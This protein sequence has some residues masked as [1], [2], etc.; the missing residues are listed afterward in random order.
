MVTKYIFVTED[1][2]S[3]VEKGIISS[4]L[5]RLLLARGFSVTIQ[6]FEPYL[7]LDSSALNPFEQG[8]CYVTEDGHE[9]D[10]ILGHY[11]RFTGV[12][13]THF[14]HITAGRIYQSVINKERRGDFLGETVRVVPHVTNE[15]KQNIKRLA[16]TGKYDFVIVEIGGVE[17]DIESGPF[18]EAARQLKKEL[19]QD[20]IHLTDISFINEVQEAE[21]SIY[22]IPLVLY[23]QHIDEEVLRMLNVS[24]AVEPDLAEWKE[25]LS[26]MQNAE[27]VVKIG[28][29]GECA[30]LQSAYKSITESLLHAA[31]HHECKL[32]MHYISSEKLNEGNVEDSL[33]GF[34]GII[35]APR[36]GQRGVEGKLTALKWCREHDMPTLG[37]CQGMQC[38]VV[39][40][41][42]NVLGLRESNSI[43][44]DPKT[45]HPVVDMMEEQKMLS[46][47]GGTMRLGAFKCRLE[48]GSVV[49]RAYGS[50]EITER[51]RHSFEFNDKYR[52]QFEDAGMKISGVNPETNLVDV[53]EISGNTWYV[54]TQYHPEYNSTVLHPNAMLKDFISAVIEKKNKK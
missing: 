31:V 35:V 6:R 18:L 40:F 48:E 3:S 38:M 9:A 19:E 8:E 37:I 1:V 5:A 34:D 54:G 30:D 49:A 14:N 33:E 11:E 26:K 36:L 32:E 50:H 47:M 39:E 43:E 15:I 51:H 52:A 22:E 28:L 16:C 44:W 2:V 4:S 21:T 24:S 13:M 29:V 10:M 17:G 27:G 46:Y 53:V 12:R 23:E 25:F 45:P 7:N 42:R 41:A 20:C